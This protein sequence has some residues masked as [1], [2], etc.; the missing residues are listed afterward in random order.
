MGGE[1]CQRV[2]QINHLIQP[3]AEKIFSL[4]YGQFEAPSKRE[5]SQKTAPKTSKTERNYTPETHKNIMKS[6]R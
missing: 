2:A 1:N 3:A 5:N 6:I 4:A